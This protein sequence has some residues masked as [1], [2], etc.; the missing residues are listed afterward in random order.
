MKISLL[1][2]CYN[3]ELT[4]EACINSCL[5][6]TD[7]F[8]QI[9]VVN[10]SSTDRTAKILA[11]FAKKI[12]VKTTPRNTRNKSH[13]QEFG[14]KFVKGE[15]VVTTDADSLLDKHFCERIRKDFSDPHIFAVSGYVSSLPYNWLTLSRAFEYVLGQD[16]HKL[17]QS[18]LNYMFVLPG[19]ASAFR[20]EAFNKHISFD[21]DTITEDLDFTYKLHHNH[22]KILYD[23]KVI[24][25]T[26]DPNTLPA[27]INQLRR[28]YAGGWQN[29]LKHYRII[30]HPVRALELSLMYAEGLVFSVVWLILPLLNFYFGLWIIA[31]YFA[32]AMLF[33]IW[34]ALKTKRWSLLLAPFPFLLLSYINSYIFLE[35]FVVIGLLKKKRLIWFK[36]ERRHLH[37]T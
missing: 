24:S 17:A 33:A 11:K 35:Q 3:E 12:T 2:P 27:Y 26:Q 18:Y 19:A 31:G 32:I 5:N 13:A 9:L 23:R 8:D 25:Y 7:H 36:P 16:L 34:A 29:L 21:H 4:I 20:V 30:K 22:L 10:D 6:Q 37:Y 1:I 14:L 28:W 15:V